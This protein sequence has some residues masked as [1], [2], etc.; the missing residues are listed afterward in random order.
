MFKVT[1]R[2]DKFF[3]GETIDGYDFNV[4][5]FPPR[6]FELESLNEDI[7]R[8]FIEEGYFT[9]TSYPFLLKPK[10]ST[11]GSIVGISLDRGI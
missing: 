3:L 6:A 4:T 2:K 9:E 5:T 7:E 1:T 8:S 11:Y 10:F